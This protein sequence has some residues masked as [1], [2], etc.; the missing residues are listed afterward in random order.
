MK[1]VK[2]PIKTVEKSPTQEV[3][4]K[5][6]KGN[7]I[8]AAIAAVPFHKY[9]QKQK[10]PKKAWTVLIDSGSDGNLIFVTKEGL[11]NIPHV[12]RYAPS[13][14]ETSNGTFKTTKVG[15]LE[16]LFPDFSRSKFFSVSPDIAELQDDDD[17]PMFN[18]IIGT[19]TLAKFGVVLDFGQNT[20]ILDH[21]S[22][23]MQP[24][25]AF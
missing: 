16:L 10:Q 4:N 20:I 21:I 17:E 15:N 14:W 23:P 2:T 9:N 22:S 11:K 19:E 8:S 25:N 1:P 3:G 6:V 7:G 5:V 24:L 18:L 12:K 13:K